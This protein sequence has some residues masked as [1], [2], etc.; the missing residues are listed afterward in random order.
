[1]KR[2]ECERCG[3]M[4]FLEQLWARRQGAAS[5]TL[6]G[7]YGPACFYEVARWVAEHE[8]PERADASPVRL[9]GPS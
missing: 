9:R 4:S 8:Q 5:A 2:G 7:W 1:M 6:V 3:R